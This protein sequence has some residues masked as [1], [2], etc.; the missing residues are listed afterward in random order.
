MSTMKY[1][2]VSKQFTAALVLGIVVLISG[3]AQAILATFDWEEHA[4]NWWVNYNLSETDNGV[5]LQAAGRGAAADGGDGAGG[6]NGFGFK[7]TYWQDAVAGTYTVLV[8]AVPQLFAVQSI[9]VTGDAGNATMPAGDLLIQGMLG[10]VE[11][12]SIDPIE[13]NAFHTYTAATSGDMGIQIDTLV[14]NGPYDPADP[15]AVLTWNN[16]IDNL[17]VD[18]IPEP[19]TVGLVG[20]G[21]LALALRRRK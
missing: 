9:D 21:L 3:S 20:L 18:A 6:A 16:K 12:W 15:S 5:T 19:A 13:D 2:R 7:A 14:W 17:T 4:G 1:A 11:Q 10:G 8:G